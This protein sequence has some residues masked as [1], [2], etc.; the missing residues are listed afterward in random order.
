MKKELRS[1]HITI[2]TDP[3]LEDTYINLLDEKTGESAGIDNISQK[4]YQLMLTVAKLGVVE[5]LTETSKTVSSLEH[6]LKGAH[7]MLLNIVEVLS[8]HHG[9]TPETLAA[10][11]NQLEKEYT[12]LY[13][14]V[15]DKR[16]VRKNLPKK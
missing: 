12:D 16:F 6:E 13:E 10:L 5:L 3:N 7:E 2:T 1:N 8:A 14:E 15:F 4:Y 9:F 11:L